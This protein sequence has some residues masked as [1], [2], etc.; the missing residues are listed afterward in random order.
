MST[1]AARTEPH[2]HPGT[3]AP[4]PAYPV[5]DSAAAGW[6]DGVYPGWWEGGHIQW[7]GGGRHIRCGGRARSRAGTGAGCAKNSA[8]LVHR[9]V[10][11]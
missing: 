1:G 8:R 3:A 9:T 2:R 11:D 10:P 7:E 4:G 5:S 6:V